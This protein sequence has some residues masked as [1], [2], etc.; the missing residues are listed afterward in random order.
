ML[1]TTFV[2]EGSFQRCFRF[3]SSVDNDSETVDEKIIQS[4][5][6]SSLEIFTNSCLYIQQREK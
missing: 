3:I 4:S 5:M 6:G 1:L 2:E